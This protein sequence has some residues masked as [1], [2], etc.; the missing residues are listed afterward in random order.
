[1]FCDIQYLAYVLLLPL[2][3]PRQITMAKSYDKTR[4]FDLF[5]MLFDCSEWNKDLNFPFDL[6]YTCVNGDSGALPVI[7]AG[8][9]PE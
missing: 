8:G 2:S 6:I 9:T 4:D 1:M 3:V 7:T 5:H